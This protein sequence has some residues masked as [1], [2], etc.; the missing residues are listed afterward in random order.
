MGTMEHLRGRQLMKLYQFSRSTL[1][2]S[3]PVVINTSKIQQPSLLPSSLISVVP[4]AQ[5]SPLYS[6]K[7]HSSRPVNEKPSEVRKKVNITTLRKLYK[8]NEPISVMTAYDYPSGHAL[9]QAGIE[10]CLVGDSLAMVALGYSST[11]EI[12]VDEMIHHCR[13]VARG[14]KSAFLIGDM[15]FGSYEISTQH[16]LQ[17]AIRFMREGRMEAIKLEGGVEM[18]D[19]VASI[20]RVGIPVLGHIGLTPQRTASLGGYRVQGKTIARAKEL[21]KDALSLQDAGCFAIV[22]EAVPAPVA[23]VITE[24]L[25]IPTIGIGAGSG[26]SGQVLVQLDMLGVYD[27]FM[28][29]FCKPYASLAPLINDALSRYK[30]EVKA[31]TFPQAEH[32]YEMSDGED[33]EAW[34]KSLMRK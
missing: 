29:K 8:K 3:A 15:P 24:Q 26:T 6:S 31:R 7:R 1:L 34:K 19:T 20:T 4:C 2:P 16:A 23:S 10:M 11:N 27:K 30:T 14:V 21:L 32:T 9:D 13:A 5:I 12:T 25:D 28:P 18:A 22:L 33:I 17:N